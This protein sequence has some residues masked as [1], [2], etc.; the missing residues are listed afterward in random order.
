MR[1]KALVICAFMG[2]VLALGTVSV[3]QAGEIASYPL[4]N[5][6][7]VVDKTDE[8][9][10]DPSISSDGHGSIK[11]TAQEPGVF[12]LAETGDL[13]VEKSRL[14]YQASV[15]TENV[16]G[17]VFLEMW[18][19]FPGQGEFFSRGLQ[20]QLTGTK[21]WTTIETYFFLK[22][23]ENPDN[24]VLNLVV[25]GIGTVWIDDIRLSVMPMSE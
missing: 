12:T 4:D 2:L 17:A 21:D 20:A 3:A 19:H 16:E 18:C 11:I 9:T 22:E 15:K 1:L 8:V 25:D 10:F 7:T 13:D 6:D 24:M 23:G 14:T 5:L